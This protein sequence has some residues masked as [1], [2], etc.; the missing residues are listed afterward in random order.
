MAN[1]IKILKNGII[2][3]KP[4][5]RTGYRYVSYTGCYKLRDQRYRYGSFHDSSVSDFCELVRIPAEKSNSR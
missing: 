2:N 4:Y 5:L 1:P 3:R